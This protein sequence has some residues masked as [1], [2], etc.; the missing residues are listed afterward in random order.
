MIYY[1]DELVDLNKVN[2]I[3]KEVN[4]QIKALKAKYFTENGRGC[5]VLL[6]PKGKRR[7]NGTGY[8]EPRR[9][10][11][12][13]L[14]SADGM[15]RFS[16]YK[17][18]IEQGK[19]PAYPEAHKLVRDD[20]ALYEED[21]E[22]LWLLTHHCKEVEK[23][24]LRIKDPEAEAKKKNEVYKEETDLRYFLFGTSSPLNVNPEEG[25]EVLKSLAS[26][27]GL[28]NAHYMEEE[29]L[30]SSLFDLFKE[31]DRVHDP[32]VNYD[33]FLELTSS[34]TKR[35][36]LITARDAITKGKLKFEKHL[37]SWRLEGHDDIFL[38]LTGSQMAQ[39]EDLLLKCVVSDEMKRIWLLSYMGVKQACSVAE[40]EKIE[41]KAL[42]SLARYLNVE[43][44]KTDTNP[45]IIRK[46]AEKLGI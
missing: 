21:I 38:K 27:V 33:T 30:K 29:E 42:K 37:Y 31:G 12:V 5:A 6:Y 3:S 8:Y 14:V 18:H 1:N 26:A 22:F 41:W 39:A 40:L 7:R 4:I 13:P 34:D 10:F 19:S 23:G 36:A 2:V 17:P 24:M 44:F 45:E 35:R 11:M 32:V 46:V 9:P 43:T 15:Y 28:K 25:L 20:T 16:E